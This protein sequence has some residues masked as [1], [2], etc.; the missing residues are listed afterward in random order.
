MSQVSLSNAHHWSERKD[1]DSTRF[2]RNSDFVH[3]IL[4]CT[5]CPHHQ[6][7]KGV[8]VQWVERL[9]RFQAH[10]GV[11]HRLHLNQE[12]CASWPSVYHS[13][14]FLQRSCSCGDL[15]RLLTRFCGSTAA[16]LSS[17]F[18]DDERGGVR[19]RDLDLSSLL[20]RPLCSTD[21]CGPADGDEGFISENSSS[22][23]SSASGETMG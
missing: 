7:F 15:G 6:S 10:F 13:V 19:S 16:E 12:A 22:D 5:H 2:F 3:C 4:H 8:L 18:C 17:T 1:L 14:A 23:T 20:K 21:R 11:P 9:K